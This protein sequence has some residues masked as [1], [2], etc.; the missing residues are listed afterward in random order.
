MKLETIDEIKKNITIDGRLGK[1]ELEFV[2]VLPGYFPGEY[3]YDAIYFAPSIRMY[4]YQRI[5]SDNEFDYNIKSFDHI[6]LDILDEI[7]KK[8][9]LLK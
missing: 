7:I 3:Y 1:I 4:L 2:S 5:F 6:S 9:K 8:G